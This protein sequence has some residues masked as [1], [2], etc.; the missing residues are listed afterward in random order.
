MRQRI[1]TTARKPTSTP[2]IRRMMQTCDEFQAKRCGP[3]CVAM[4]ITAT[5]NM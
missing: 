2:A 4:G 5:F 3:E 1:N